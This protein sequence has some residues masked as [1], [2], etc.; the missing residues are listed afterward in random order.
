MAT[1]STSQTVSTIANLLGVNVNSSN[2][3]SSAKSVNGSVENLTTARAVEQAQLSDSSISHTLI[4]KDR[5][6]GGANIMTMGTV[7]DAAL[8]EIMNC[9]T[10]LKPS[11]KYLLTLARTRLNLLLQVSGLKRLRWICRH[12]WAHYSTKANWNLNCIL[13][14]PI[15]QKHFWIS[16]ICMIIQTIK[17][18]SGQIAA[19]EVDMVTTSMLPTILK[20]APSVAKT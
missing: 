5:L 1:V 8:A 9:L 19:L 11:W 3:L 17:L 18:L 13:E 20:L 12:M 15:A 14:T 7:S 4:F 2:Q 6:E 16:S 10:K